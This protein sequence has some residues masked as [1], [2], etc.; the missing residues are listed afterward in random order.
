MSTPTVPSPIN[1]AR[2]STVDRPGNVN[3]GLI[4]GLNTGPSNS[5]KPYS[6]NNGKNKAA[7]KNTATNVGS[8]LEKQVLSIF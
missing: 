2:L 3:N 7:N 5:N 6:I 8:K 4:T 1:E